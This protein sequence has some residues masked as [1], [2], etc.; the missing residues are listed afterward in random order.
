MSIH[1]RWYIVA[2]VAAAIAGLIGVLAVFGGSTSPRKY[3]ASKYSRAASDDLDGAQA[4]R[5]PLAPSVVAAAIAGAWRPADRVTDASG[6]YLRYSDDVIT[7]FPSGKGSL[8]RVEDADRAYRRYH[9]TVHGYWGF[10]SG[11]GEAG[12]GGGPGSGK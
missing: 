12:R 3:V 8:I 4:Y 11:Q 9:S 2:G 5:S 6:H 10:S 1:R 7:V